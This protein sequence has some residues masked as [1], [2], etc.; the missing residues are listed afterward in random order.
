MKDAGLGKKV[1]RKPFALIPGDLIFLA[2]S[3]ERTPPQIGDMVPEPD[4]CSTVCRHRVILKEAGYD[5]PQPFP[6]FRDWLVPA[7][8]HFLLDFLELR[9]HAVAAGLSLQREAP[10]A[11]SS[12]DEINPRNLKVSGL[13]TPRRAR[14]TVAK[15]P[16][17]IRR[18]FSG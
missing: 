4:E 9:S 11:R 8:S 7:P 15:Q 17:S 12:A 2:A 3:L 14:W 6:L 1:I 5:L 10:A 18:V 16:N 13:P